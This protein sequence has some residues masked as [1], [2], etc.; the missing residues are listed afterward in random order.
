L[1]FLWESGVRKRRAAALRIQARAQFLA[2]SAR[3]ASGVKRAYLDAWSAR[4]ARLAYGQAEGIM[5]E[6]VNSAEARFAEGDIAG[7][8]LRRLRF[9]RARFQRRRAAVELDLEEAEQRLGTLLLASDDPRRVSVLELEGEGLASSVPGDPVARALIRR[10]EI[11][12]AEAFSEARERETSLIRASVFQ[13]TSVTGGLKRQTDGMEGL[14]MGLEIPLPLTDRRGGAVDAAQAAVLAAESELDLLRRA[15]TQQVSIASSRLSTAQR[16]QEVFGSRSAQEAEE[17]L[18]IARLSFAEGEMRVVDLLDAAKAFVEA[19]LLG[20]QVRTDLWD[21][22]F[23]L[24]Q[25]V[26]GFSTDSDNGVD[27]R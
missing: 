23:E 27:E 15:V 3:L 18:A 2:D 22:Y 9:E 14:F 8:D 4:E 17:L 13:G 6:L 11:V 10:P 1:E 24:E 19:R 26:G 21:A 20:I 12:A 16:Q 7:Y 5:A 25:A